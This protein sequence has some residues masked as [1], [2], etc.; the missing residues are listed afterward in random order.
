MEAK[1]H[2]VQKDV[3]HAVLE[4]HA[5]HVSMDIPYTRVHAINVHK[6]VKVAVIMVLPKLPLVQP[7]F[8]FTY[9]YLEE[10]V[11]LV[12]I[13]TAPLVQHKHFVLHASKDML[14]ILK[15]LAKLVLRI[16]LLVQ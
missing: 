4:L 9:C 11:Q 10:L 15:E 3:N 2:S 6:I 5:L 13:P 16:V 1:E 14:L 8:L 12:L 7:V